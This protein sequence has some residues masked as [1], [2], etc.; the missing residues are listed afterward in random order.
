MAETE[1]ITETA[2]VPAPEADAPAAPADELDQLLAEFDQGT[3]QPE[4]SV[5]PAAANERERAVA[6][7][8][9]A[10]TE[11]YAIDAR[12]QQLQTEAQALQM[13]I[14]RKDALSAFAEIR[15]G[16]PPELFDDATVD[17]WVSARGASDPAIQAAWQNRAADPRTYQR[18]LNKLASEFGEKFRRYEPESE[19]DHAAVALAVKNSGGR[20]PPEPPPNLGRM[21]DSEYR[22]HVRDNYGYDPS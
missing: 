4:Q 16:L 11:G 13:E 9:R 2:D 19:V 14:D 21:S 6:E 1:Q 20:A 5:N 22:Q 8:L 10:I 7:N 3:A 12:R 15:G 17:A 18:T